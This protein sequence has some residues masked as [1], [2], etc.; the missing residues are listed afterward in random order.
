M[1][2][3]STSPPED[4]VKKFRYVGPVKKETFAKQWE[5]ERKPNT[6]YFAKPQ[7]TSLDLD[8]VWSIKRN[9]T[10]SQGLLPPNKQYGQ[11]VAGKQEGSS[12]GNS[13]Y[14]RH[15]AIPMN[16]KQSNEKTTFKAQS[17][18]KHKT[19]LRG[20]ANSVSTTSS[21]PCND[22][23]KD[24]DDES[25]F[26]FELPSSQTVSIRKNG[27]PGFKH[28]QPLQGKTKKLNIILNICFSHWH[29][30]LNKVC[31]VVLQPSFYQ[32]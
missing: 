12:F 26:D 20:S 31:T 9:V 18:I 32:L 2:E 1:K 7:L 25:E 29:Y 10:V 22:I 27:A 3:H 11:L 13:I 4:R 6:N 21:S 19:W 14:S 15:K 23:A 24:D 16:A 8:S 28:V 30:V 5:Q 17:N